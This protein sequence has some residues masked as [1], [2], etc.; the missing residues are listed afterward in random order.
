LTNREALLA[1]LHGFRA[2]LDVLEEAVA[3]GNAGRIE[4][5][6][7]AGAEAKRGWGAL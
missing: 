4:N 3:S 1:A 2:E 7:A 5:F 6:F